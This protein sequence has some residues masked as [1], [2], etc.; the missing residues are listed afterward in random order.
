[1]FGELRKRIGK[2]YE[3]V[4]S[5]DEVD[6]VPISYSPCSGYPL[7]YDGMSSRHVSPS[8]SNSWTKC[9]FVFSLS[10]VAF[11]SSVAVYLYSESPNIKISGRYASRKR[12]LLQGVGGAILMYVGLMVLSGY[13][14]YRHISRRQQRPRFDDRTK[15]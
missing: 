9:C 6:F 1:M 8:D 13:F 2:G 12:D 7:G 14:W 4:T 15:D 3:R 5:D 10:G 11:L